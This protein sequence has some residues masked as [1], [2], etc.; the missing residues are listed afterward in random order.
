MIKPLVQLPLVHVN[1]AASADHA[2]RA[3]SS[4]GD[5]KTLIVATMR[6][7]VVALVVALVRAA[8]VVVTNATTVGTIDDI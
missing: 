7:L 4:N 1:L 3:R 6:L 5:N 8:D 2:H